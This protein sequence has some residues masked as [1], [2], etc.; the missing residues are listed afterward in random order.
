MIRIALHGA[1]GRMGRAITER[2]DASSTMELALALGPKNDPALGQDVGQLAGI[3]ASG[4]VIVSD[5]DLSNVDVVIDFSMPD[6]T[7]EIAKRCRAAQIPLVSGTTGLADAEIDVL[8]RL[9]KVVPVVW[10]PNMSVGVTLLFH[11]AQYASRLAGE[12]F[13]AEIVEMH[14]R[15]KVDS[16]SGTALRL[17]E[18]VA[19]GKDLDASSFVFGRQGKTGPRTAKEIGVMTLRGGGVVG[20]HTLILAAPGERIELSHRAQDRSIF[21]RGALRAAQWVVGRSPGRYDMAHVIGV[22]SDSK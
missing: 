9:S 1:S 13:D 12:D 20:D 21:A 15:H 10:A 5:A 6:G 7:A 2:I 11:L 3:G 19:A 4:V 17:A 22:S 14:H 16:P 18:C 8:D